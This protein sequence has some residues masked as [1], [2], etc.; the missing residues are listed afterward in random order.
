MPH[1]TFSVLVHT[2]V[3]FDPYDPPAGVAITD[4]QTKTYFDAE[5]LSLLTLALEIGRG[6]AAPIVAMWLYDR[7]VKPKESKPARKIRINER[8]I[9]VGSREEFVRLIE[10]EIRTT[11]ADDSGPAP[12]KA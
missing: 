9:T 5:G 4:H 3:T 10:R 7:F 6:I 1:L 2:P 12:P 8:E 11:D